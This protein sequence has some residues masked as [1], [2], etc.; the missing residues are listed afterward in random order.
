MYFVK[1][2]IRQELQF[3]EIGGGMYRNRSVEEK[4]GR[5]EMEKI[6]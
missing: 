2:F 4:E 5:D 1:Y 6:V 3:N